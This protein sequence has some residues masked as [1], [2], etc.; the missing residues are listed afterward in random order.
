M[1]RTLISIGYA[2]AGLGLAV[3]LA[4]GGYAIAGRDLSEPVR[5]VRPTQS[6]VGSAGVSPPQATASPDD[7]PSP[8]DSASPDDK[9]GD[10]SGS[11]DDNSGS[12]SSNSGSGS[13]NSGSGSSNS[14]SGS[15]DDKP[16]DD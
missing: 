10:N 13:S 3:G 15:D 14:G 12:G 5:I 6:E 11:D 2:L 9:G 1:R 7:S 4:A 8:E 16:D